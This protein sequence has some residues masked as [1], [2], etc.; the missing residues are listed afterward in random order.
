MAVFW[1]VVDEPMPHRQKKPYSMTLYQGD[2]LTIFEVN[3]EIRI[4]Y[5][6]K[7]GA[8]SKFPLTADER[9][10]VLVELEDFETNRRDP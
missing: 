5:Q 6:T 10:E 2:R 4:H 7:E 9:L 1:S 8:L 3:R